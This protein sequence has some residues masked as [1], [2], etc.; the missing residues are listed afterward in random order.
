MAYK[1]GQWLANCDR[2]DWTF[3]SGQLQIEPVTTWMVCKRCLDEINPQDYIRPVKE[4]NIP[5]SRP[6]NDGI[7]VSPFDYVTFNYSTDLDPPLGQDGRYEA[8]DGIESAAIT[9]GYVDDAYF[10]LVYIY[11]F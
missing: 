2:C 10:E 9:P 8:H 5:W 4:S 7:D 6:D 3:L 11:N 1:S